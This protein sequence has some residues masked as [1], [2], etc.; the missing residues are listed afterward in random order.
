MHSDIS[1]QKNA[2][3]ILKET[4]K[5]LSL[6][7][8]NG[9]VGIWEWNIKTDEV[10]FDSRARAILELEPGARVDDFK[11][12][13][14]LLH[15]E[16]VDHFVKAHDRA[17]KEDIPLDTIFRLKSGN[18]IIST[19]GSTIKDHNG[20]PVIMSGVCYDVSG[21]KK[22]TD[23]TLLK[24]SQELL[25]SNKEL[26][27]FAYVASHDLQEPLR[28]VTSFTQLLQKQYGDKLDD[29]ANEYIHYAVDGSKRMYELLNGL[30][31]YSRIHS[32]GKAFIM[33]DLNKVLESV[34]DN[35]SM[36]ITEREAVIK[37]DELPTVYADESQMILLFQNLISNS[38]KFSTNPPRIFISSKAEGDNYTFY[39]RDE[40]IG[41]ELQYFERIFLIFQRLMP[42]DQYEGTGI[43]LSICKR[44][45]E[46]HEGKIWLESE[47]GKGT[48]FIFIIPKQQAIN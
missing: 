11:S 7:L 48:T 41:I 22:S 28:M 15:E 37:A 19:K 38:I 42:R 31:A 29:S 1:I 18:T 2:E 13:E 21:L 12:F 43:G 34:I 8:E 17:V 32:K 44:I 39:V 46:R 6:A 33:V 9:N 10:T 24:L 16:D 40:G 26:E 20:S 36:K 35:L 45:I 27:N 23:K 4:Q 5:K 14:T 25:R 3:D 47:Y 30:L